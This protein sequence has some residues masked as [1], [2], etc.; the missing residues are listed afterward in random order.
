MCVVCIGLCIE[1]DVGCGE[2][3]VC[4]K[5]DGGRTQEAAGI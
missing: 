1:M 2:E 4:A 5:R 3:A